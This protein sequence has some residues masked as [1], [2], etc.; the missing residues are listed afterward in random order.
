[1]YERCLAQARGVINASP[2]ELSWGLFCSQGQAEAAQAALA[3]CP[4]SVPQDPDCS[5]QLLGTR[6]ILYRS[7]NK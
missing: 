7:S 2:L 1:M 3:H 4:D 5:R 6:Y